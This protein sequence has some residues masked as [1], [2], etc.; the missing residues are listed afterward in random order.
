MKRVKR[1]QPWRCLAVLILGLVGVSDLAL[2]VDCNGNGVEDADEIAAG[3]VEDCNFNEIPDGCEGPRFAFSQF[4]ELEF[5]SATR[6]A[7]SADFNGDGVSDLAIGYF[8]GAA[9]RFA[10][11]AG[12]FDSFTEIHFAVS[13]TN[14]IAW[15]GGDFDGDGDVDL[16]VLE[17]S[18]LIVVY[19][20]GDGTFE[21]GPT[22][23]PGGRF[24]ALAV[25]D[26]A[27][28]GTDDI[29]VTEIRNDLLKVIPTNATGA[30]EEPVEYTAGNDPRAVGVG[31][32]NGDRVVDLVVVNRVSADLSLLYNDGTGIFSESVS[33]PGLGSQTQ[34]L[35]VADF[36]GDGLADVAVGDR[37]SATVL[38]NQDGRAFSAP[39][40]LLNDS[41]NV[42]AL[43]SGDID[44]D[45]DVDIV[46]SYV[47]PELT[48][49]F[50]NRGDGAFNAGFPLLLPKYSQIVV[51]DVDAD[52]ARDLVL[53]PAQAKG[54]T[55]AWNRQ[56]DSAVPFSTLK[57]YPSIRPHSADIGDLD[58]DGDLDIAIG[59]NSF[60]PLT[61]MIN[62]GNG[63]YT[64]VRLDQGGGGAFSIAVD[65]LDG[66]GDLD[67]IGG[68]FDGGGAF[69]LTNDG[70]AKFT[71]TD[72]RLVSA[73]FHVLTGDV[74]GNGTVDVVA[75]YSS[76]DGIGVLFTDGTAHF[77]RVDEYVVGNSPRATALGDLDGDGDLDLAV[78]NR[79]S[80][81]LFV[82]ENDGT[83]VFAPPIEVPIPG[84]PNFVIA[85][86]MDVDGHIDLLT[87]NEAESEIAILWSLGGDSIAFEP[88]L[89]IGVGLEPYSLIAVDLD[90]DG[91][92]DIA[93]VQESGV[94]EDS[95]FCVST[96]GAT[97]GRVSIVL[98]QGRRVFSSANS[99][100]TGSGPRFLVA[101][102]VDADL[103]LDIISANRRS[104][105]ITVLLSEL[106]TTEVPDFLES[107]C[108]PAEYFDLSTQ[109]RS[110]SLSRRIGKYVVAARDDPNLYPALF[111]NVNRF[112][113]HEDFLAEVFPDE[114]GFILDD[115]SRYG[116]IV[117]R[118][119]TR[120]YYVGALDLRQ[121]D[122]GFLYTFNVV[123]DTAFDP[124]EVLSQQEVSE[125]YG[126]LSAKFLLEPLAY[127]PLSQ[128]DL[129]QAE[130]W[131][132]PDFPMF[133][134][135]TPP[136]FQFE[137]YTLGLGYGRL[138]ILTLEDFEVANRE[139][140]FTFQDGV[141]IE[142]VSPPDIEGVV[143][144]V[145]TGGV[146]GELAHL[147][148]RTARRGTPNAFVSN[149][150]EKFGDFEGDLVRVE[151]FPENFF[152]TPVETSEAEQFWEQIRRELPEPPSLDLGYTLV[153]GF[154]EM[155]L[156]DRPVGRYGGKATNLA[157]L[158]RVILNDG[159][160][161]GFLE[162][163][164]G[165]PAHYHGQFM[166]SNFRGAQT[167][168]EYIQEIVAREDVRT[169][170]KLRFEL[171][172]DFRQFVRDNGVIE[173][174]LVQSLALKIESVFGDSETMVRFRSSSNIEDALVFNGAG[175]YESTSVCAL[176]TLDSNDRNSSYCDP[177]RSSE[178]TIERAL[179]KVWSSLWTFRAHEERTFYQIDPN[180]AVM[181]IAVTRAFLNEDANG[182]AF[183][184]SPR[185]VEDKRYV[186]T[187]QV[188]EGS[189]V[190]P[191]AGMTVERTLLGVGDDGDVEN[192]VRSRAS[193]QVDP[194]VVVMSDE[195]LRELARF[196]W[197]IENAWQFELPEEIDR[198]QVILDFE[199]KVEP[200]GGLAVKQVRPFLIPTSDLRT[201]RFELEIPS[202]TILCGV[203]APESVS[204]PF[205]AADPQLEYEMKSQVWLNGGVFEMPTDEGAFERDL[206]AEL[207]FG[208]EQELAQ[209]LSPGRFEFQ[210]A[211]D[212]GNQTTY[213]FNYTQDFGLPSGFSLQVS[214]D[215]LQ[216]VGRGSIALERRLVLDDFYNTFSLRMEAVLDGTPRVAFSSCSY[217]E[218][219]RWELDLELEGGSRISLVERF[220]AEESINLTGRASLAF[221]KVDIEGVSRVVRDYW[222]LIYTSRRHNVDVVYWVVLDPELNLPGVEQPV[223]VVEVSGFDGLPATRYEC[224]TAMVRYLDRDYVMVGMPVITSC[225][226]ETIVDPGPKF[227]RGDVDDGG[228]TITDVILVLQYLFA[229][230]TTP[231]CLSSADANDDGRVDVRDAVSVVLHLFGGV[232]TLPPPF[233]V[234]GTDPT[235]DGLPCV[236]SA[237]CPGS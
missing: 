143:G 212:E 153:D 206:I 112:R 164:F 93:A 20:T 85:V 236:L 146:Q 118:R 19:N 79:F 140:R 23:S 77:D 81:N 235:P 14:P 154:L 29:V 76:V 83:G 105:D 117:G 156:T 24:T 128:A 201:P 185:D 57:A 179:K 2:S 209:P 53:V 97:G 61:V 180:D 41:L 124:R 182:V 186:I 69:L 172:D 70:S 39:A 10:E 37:E 166:Q 11:R 9:I 228:V 133:F 6:A 232:S 90:E 198:E 142:E 160:L 100:L 171:L 25:A 15:S 174:G 196:M 88:A 104:G 1:S 150:R 214:I 38:L 189:V 31:D 219:P 224:P 129:D 205:A 36:T 66:D 110:T 62:D 123:T 147:P 45:G 145:F 161:D 226:K 220:L 4:S 108:T 119:A 190:S 47:Q 195:H 155:D 137:A 91:Q 5:E 167:Y 130:T 68:N 109:S 72:R 213:T 17:S 187:A 203:F 204:R 184:G 194:G 107:V 159:T 32:L 210:T 64:D 114:F 34:K 177:S 54:I 116:E 157:R 162:S 52:D 230:G 138:R 8:G 73:P 233:S 131:V 132:E 135:N 227:L 122:D 149:V 33:I 7:V 40:L 101:G 134:D 193:N 51:A 200:G 35:V 78:A 216:F 221:A 211:A 50:V 18:R 183:T 92:P 178:R 44:G 43:A 115:P 168:Q 170:S 126:R 96:C 207:R 56:L 175:L 197:R 58:G 55:I 42:A 223:R 94:D 121:R 152:V 173:A 21:E 144:F 87:A 127:A 139:G 98:N 181:A 16:V 63:A 103:D 231:P 169:D 30:F 125:L 86:D 113:L 215:N 165:I 46:V 136:P 48:V 234:C 237:T 59:H 75:T 28:D 99:F 49:A 217:R 89:R 151:V 141:V 95:R 208:P 111:Q 218:L 176:D 102:D 26:F 27:D 12:A 191:P 67:I 202:G 120:D 225:V 106:S 199:F 3:E 188:G 84:G 222:H 229:R 82:L 163:G 60:Q 192:I 71:F 65:D 13:T 148:I 80:S 74:D 22:L 158:Q